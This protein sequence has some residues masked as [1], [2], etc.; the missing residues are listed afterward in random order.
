MIYSD[1]YCL[2]TIH[3]IE[4][5]IIFVSKTCYITCYYSRRKKLF[6]L[7]TLRSLYTLH[8]PFITLPFYC[9]RVPLY[10]DLCFY[11]HPKC[12]QI[13]RNI[14]RHRG[15][16]KTTRKVYSSLLA[17]CNIYYCFSNRRFAERNNAR[18]MCVRQSVC[19]LIVPS[20]EVK[21]LLPFL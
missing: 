19:A 8:C 20:I 10:S 3:T 6:L 2:H 1:R 4:K 16:K 14:G 18:S 13:L 12:G 9:H 15:R 11:L 7:V 21:L 5:Y 17:N